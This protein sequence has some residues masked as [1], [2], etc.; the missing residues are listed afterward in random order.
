MSL[1]ELQ[2]CITDFEALFQQGDLAPLM[3]VGAIALNFQQIKVCGAELQRTNTQDHT[4][5]LLCRT[6]ETS[7]LNIRN[8]T[9]GEQHQPHILALTQTKEFAAL[10]NAQAFLTQ[11]QQNWYLSYLLQELRDI[12]QKSGPNGNLLTS[13]ENIYNNPELDWKTKNE[14]ID[15]A[16]HAYAKAS[17]R[18]FF[19]DKSKPL[20]IALLEKMDAE[21]PTIARLSSIDEATPQLTSH[22]A[23]P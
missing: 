17:A 9:D 4:K 11:Q 3:E 16:I 19:G 21:R 20:K 22:A 1:D 10:N 6:I 14:R 18:T 23:T 5:F 12:F 2:R 15:T 7:I 8:Y 13:I